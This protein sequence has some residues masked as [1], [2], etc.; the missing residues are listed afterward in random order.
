MQAAGSPDPRAA[1]VQRI[2]AARAALRTAIDPETR[3]T[4]LDELGTAT[5]QLAELIVQEEGSLKSPLE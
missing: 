2:T 3:N 1:L 5:R 4:L